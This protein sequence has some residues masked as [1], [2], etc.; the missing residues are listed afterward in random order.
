MN[1]RVLVRVQE[2][3]RIFDRYDVII[4]SLIYQI[5]NRSQRRTLATAGRTRNQH[6]AVFD[7]YDLFQLLRQVEIA[8]TRRSHGYNTHDDRVRPTLLEDVD[9]ETS[10][11]RNAE[12]KVSR[13]GFFQSV[14]CYQMISDNQLR[15]S[16]GMRRRQLL[17]TRNANGH[18][19]SGQLDLRRSA[20][21]EYQIAH[22]I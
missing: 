22:F 15:D 20:G 11:A 14:Q 12:R 3:D 1:R 18:E 7:V 13:A 5:D 2:L 17:Q 8:E 16:C 19:F 9:A 10:V 4:M 6:N 21:A